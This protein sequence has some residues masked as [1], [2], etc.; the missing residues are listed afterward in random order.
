MSYKIKRNLLISCFWILFWFLF[1]VSN[2]NIVFSLNYWI[3]FYLITYIYVSSLFILNIVSVI[4]INKPTIKYSLYS[5]ILLHISFLLYILIINVTFLIP[6]IF[7]IILCI[8][9][10]FIFIY[11]LS[12]N[13]TSIIYSNNKEYILILL[14]FILLN[15]FFNKELNI[16]FVPEKELKTEINNKKW[17][18]EESLYK[19]NTKIDLSQLISFEWELYLYETRY[20]VNIPFLFS[21]DDMRSVYRFRLYDYKI[22]KNIS[23]IYV[24]SLRKNI[25]SDIII[26]RWL[27]NSDSWVLESLKYFEK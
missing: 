23:S 15:S 2:Y 21:V 8:I 7:I 16:P 14:I 26:R 25:L 4:A 5:K 18:L 9:W 3:L 11:D 20:L 22:N 10:N 12:K 17:F 27:L 6:L 1:L 24:P 19:K 13:S